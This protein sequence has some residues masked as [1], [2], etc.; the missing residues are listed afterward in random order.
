MIDKLTKINKKSEKDN[1]QMED[2]LEQKKLEPIE[3]GLQMEDDFE[4]NKR[5]ALL[6]VKNMALDQLFDEEHQPQIDKATRRLQKDIE[7]K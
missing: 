7:T 3:E 4:K 1:K 2:M 6:E 5:I